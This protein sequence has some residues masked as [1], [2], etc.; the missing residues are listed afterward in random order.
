MEVALEEVMAVVLVEESE[1]VKEEV[2]QEVLAAE[3]VAMVM[4]E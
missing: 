2:R 1:E 4:E 3:V